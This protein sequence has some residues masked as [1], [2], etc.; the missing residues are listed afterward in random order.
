MWT[1]PSPAEE[2][3]ERMRKELQEMYLLTHP[4]QPSEIKPQPWEIIRDKNK[5]NFEKLH[6]SNLSPQELYDLFYKINHTKAEQDEVDRSF[7]L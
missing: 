6:K 3:A 4:L 1:E 2:L 5:E 7:K